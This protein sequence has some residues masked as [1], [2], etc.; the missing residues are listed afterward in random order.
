MTHGNRER[1]LGYLLSIAPRRATNGQICQATGVQPHQQVYQLTR[2][3]AADGLICGEQ[4]GREWVF[5]ATE[6]ITAPGAA[7]DAPG[8]R[9]DLGSV[10]LTARGFENLAR[11]VMSRLYGIP[12]APGEVPGVPKLF[13][14]ISADWRIVGD[15]KFFTMVR[16]QNRPPAKFATI[17][18][19]VWLLE[20]T[21]APVTFLVFGN[22]R[23]VPELWLERFGHL[24]PRVAFYFL[25]GDGTL[26]ELA[27]P[28]SEDI[29]A[30][31]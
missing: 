3:L 19:Y 13:D 30:D 20:K 7:V 11:T 15:A 2:D 17:A 26:E 14:L 29:H 27:R 25:A 28:E 23:R 4:R 31:L 18:E 21:G 16:G 6:P 1:I 22:D 9:S 5:W 8:A 24:A 12:L 10:G